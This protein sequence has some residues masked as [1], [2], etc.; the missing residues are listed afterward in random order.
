MPDF[1]FS[2]EPATKSA[3]VLVVEDCKLTQHVITSLLKELTPHVNQAFDG[4]EGINMCDTS[5][6]DI[7]FMDM[8]M[9]K[10]NGKQLPVSECKDGRKVGGRAGGR[11]G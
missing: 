10:I 4:E 7:I 11:E 9:P 1:I 2:E 8:N 3:S 5:Q 6:Y